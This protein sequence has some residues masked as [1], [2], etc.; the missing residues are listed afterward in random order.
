MRIR[1]KNRGIWSP[2]RID[3][4]IG[5]DSVIVNEN[6]LDPSKESVE[7]YFKGKD[8]SGILNFTSAEAKSLLRA[9]GQNM[10]LAKMMNFSETDEIK[11]AVGEKNKKKT[12]RKV[13]KVRKKK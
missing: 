1:I 5:I 11:K 7:V 9:L 8:S 2:Q 13:G 3:S 6:L 12:R 10:G 4:R